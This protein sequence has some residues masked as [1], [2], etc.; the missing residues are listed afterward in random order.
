MKSKSAIYITVLSVLF[1]SA[2]NLNVTDDNNDKVTRTEVPMELVTKILD[3]DSSTK[4]KDH[5]HCSDQ[6]IDLTMCPSEIECDK[7]GNECL[8]C[9]CDLNCRFGQDSWALCEAPKELKCIGS[10]TFNRK[11]KCSYCY[12]SD[13]RLVQCDEKFGCESVA[14][15]HD[16]SYVAT[17]NV[18]SSV[19]CFGKRSFPKNQECNWTGGHRWLTT[20]ILSITLGGFGA[21]R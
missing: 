7:L 21:D 17:C 14:D 6:T 3:K 11:F 19:L 18:S 16:R 13:K 20:L 5:M 15:P 8:N 4:I 9:S 12:L 2:A 10:R 1:V